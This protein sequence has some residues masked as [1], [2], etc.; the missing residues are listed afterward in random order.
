LSIVVGAMV[1][2]FFLGLVGQKAVLN[3]VAGLFGRT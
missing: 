2:H 1:A 3:F